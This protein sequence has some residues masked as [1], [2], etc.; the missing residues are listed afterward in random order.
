MSAKLTQQQEE[1]KKLI[2]KVV[3]KELTT[4]EAA[5]EAGLTI[6]AIQKAVQRYK[7]MAMIL[8]FTETLAVFV[9][10]SDEPK[11]KPESLIFFRI[12]G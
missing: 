9:K 1:R 11:T 6:R 4:R 12:P 5:V 3:N 2:L 8:L 10:I 7:N